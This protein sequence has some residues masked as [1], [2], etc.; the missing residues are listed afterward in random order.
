MSVK[1]LN[2]QQIL[3]RNERTIS[4][5]CEPG[6]LD[7]LSLLLVIKQQEQGLTKLLKSMMTIDKDKK[8][9]CGDNIQIT[10]I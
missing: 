5:V 4:Y 3:P 7:Q 1:L 2:I 9:I 8:C 6:I 10:N